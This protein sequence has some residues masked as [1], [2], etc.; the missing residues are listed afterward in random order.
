MS[1]GWP[2]TGLSPEQPLLQGEMPPP[3]HPPRAYQQQLTASVLS[4]GLLET[5]LTQ[6]TTVHWFRLDALRLHD[7]PAFLE[8]VTAGTQFKAVFIIDPWFNANYNQG[9]PAVNVWRFLLEALHDIDNRLQKKP[10]STRLNV[11]YGQPTIIFPVLFKKWNVTKLTFQASQVSYESMKH[12]EIVKVLGAQENVQISSHYSHTLYSPQNLIA[13]N[14]GQVPSTYKDF[15]RLLPVLGRPT[16]PIPEPDPMSIFIHSG[17]GGEQMD[18][19]VEGKIPTLQELGFSQSESLY[20]NSWV[21][22]ETEALSRLSSFCARRAMASEDP[23]NWL[24]SK[25]TLSP[26]I[27]FGCLSVRLLFSQLRQ[28]ASTSTRGQDLFEQ[29]TKNLLLREFAFLV[30]YAN[31]QFDVMQGNSLCLQLPWDN[32]PEY[33]EAWRNGKTGYPWIDAV[34]RQVRQEG[35]AHFLARQSIAVFLTRGYL[36]VSWVHGK[37]FFQEF[38]LDFELPVSS[39]CWMQSSCSGFFCNQVESYDPCAVGKQMDLEGHYIKTYV[40]ELK[41][42]P[43]EYIHQPWDAP[44]YIQKQADCVI[45]RDY[46]KP[47][48]ESCSQGELCCKRIQSI[49][50]ALYNVYGEEGAQ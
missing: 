1:E 13:L 50:S 34:I 16:D 41:D 19:L 35:W 2:S 47:I 22:G 9:G 49:M 23:V 10:Y 38:M 43:S 30:G 4:Q 6:P 36:W 15:R 3:S 40:T 7:N 8:A 42:F 39:T 33:L 44:L 20:S 32:A 37:E 48:V 5:T 26:Y 17:S 28:F 27:R 45:G 46:P 24:M 21:G 25:D 11:L 14:N 29:L 31:P 12:D 18:K